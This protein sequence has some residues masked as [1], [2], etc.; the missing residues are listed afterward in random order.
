MM[1]MS[2]IVSLK[3]APL[4]A[5][6]S[7]LVVRMSNGNGPGYV[8]V[9]YEDDECWHVIEGSLT[10]RLPDGEV[11]APAGTTVFVP[12]GVAHDYCETDGPATYLLILSPRM[13]ELIGLLHKTPFDQHA[14]LFKQYAS[15]ILS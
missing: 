3:G 10:F 4:L 14:E 1:G 5:A 2:A 9:H 12:A 8:H 13:N 11:V 6:G 7:N 15:E